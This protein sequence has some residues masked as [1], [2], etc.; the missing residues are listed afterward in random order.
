MKKFL[1][2]FLAGG[3]GLV[4]TIILPGA[5]SLSAPRNP[6]QK[7]EP[8]EVM[9]SV[10]PHKIVKDIFG[11]SIAKGFYAIEI[12]LGNQSDSDWL[13][14]GFVLASGSRSVTPSSVSLLM[15]QTRGDKTARL[16][17]AGF[18]RNLVISKDTQERT[19]LFVPRQ[20]LG[21]TNNQTD[22][23]VTEV[24]KQITELRPILR[25]IQK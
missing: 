23:D 20:A 8:L 25:K 5:I 16:C 12:N 22:F 1:A 17:K 11:K 2:P 3:C 15:S 7:A 21:V 6:Q 18:D 4:L 14:E 24:Q 9:W 13:V 19:V 10:M